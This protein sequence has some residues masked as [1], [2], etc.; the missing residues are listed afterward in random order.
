MVII[1]YDAG[2]MQINAK[3]YLNSKN[4][5]IGKFNTLIN[6]SIESDR[7]Y[8]TNAVNA[9]FT[10]IDEEINDVPELIKLAEYNHAVNVKYFTQTAKEKNWDDAKLLKKINSSCNQLNNNLKKITT[11]KRKYE[12]F[13]TILETICDQTKKGA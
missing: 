12:K 4:A 6:M 7:A 2:E 1:K 3:L 13:K 5:T 9:W 10:A 8:A 11:R